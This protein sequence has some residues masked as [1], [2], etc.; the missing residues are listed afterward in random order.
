MSKEESYPLTCPCCG[1]VMKVDADSRIILS[2]TPPKE[3]KEAASFESRMS[4]LKDEKK[5]AEDKF[6]ESIRA[7]KAKKEVLEKKFKD[8]FQKA[9]EG[10]IGPMKRDID[11]D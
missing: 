3:D 5:V 8:L 1:C 11:L 10:P 7:E 9:K 4:A 6:Q 2:H